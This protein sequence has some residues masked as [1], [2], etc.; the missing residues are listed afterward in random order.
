MYIGFPTTMAKASSP[1]TPVPDAE[2][3][4]RPTQTSSPLQEMRC[5]SASLGICEIRCRTP[6]VV[7]EAR[8]T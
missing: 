6:G 7:E 1:A 2:I 4:C 5:V 3:L 8:R